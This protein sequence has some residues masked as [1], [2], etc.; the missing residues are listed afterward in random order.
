M[1]E[2]DGSIGGGQLL[3]TAIGLSALTLKPVRI[4]NIRKG[5]EEGKPGLKPQHMMGIKVAG[6][7]CQAEVKGLKENSLEVE[8]NPKKLNVSSQDIDIGTAGSISLLLQNLSPILLF[9]SK[10][11]NLEIKGGTETKWSPTIQYIKYVTYPILKMMGAELKLEIIKHGYYPK[12]GGTVSVKSKP[13]KELNHLI[14]LNR[15]EI[16]GIHV[17]SVC[18]SLPPDVAERQGQSALRT[19]QYYASKI[20]VSM[21]YKSVPSLSPGSSVTCYALCQNSV[22]G[23][24]SLGELGVRAETVGEMAV[25]ELISSLNTRAALDR[26]M[27][28]QILIFLAI[29]KGKS[30]VKVEEIT[31][32]CRTNIR[33]IEEILPV[34]FHIDENKKEISVEGIGFRA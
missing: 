4:I 10:P 29:A 2:I 28:D 23:G 18:G 26:Y 30:Q 11:V 8:F 21:S 17:D 1:I 9:G 16:K 19:I 22:L 15:G 5:K 33:V 13:V 6:N 32:H 14:C 20:K 34:E 12:G 3:R 7:F 31:D 25:E 27:A 24:S